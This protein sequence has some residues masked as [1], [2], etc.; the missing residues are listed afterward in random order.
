M[1]RLFGSVRPVIN[2]PDFF[3]L[4]ENPLEAVERKTRD[5]TETVGNMSKLKSN[6]DCL[7][8]LK[9]LELCMRNIANLRDANEHEHEAA[10]DTNN[11]PR[12]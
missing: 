5:L 2:N 3:N 10:G 6:P 7:K 11:S 9:V 8:A 4:K 12:R 1:I